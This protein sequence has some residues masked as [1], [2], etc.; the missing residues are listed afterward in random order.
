MS[1]IPRIPFLRRNPRVCRLSA[2]LCY[3]FTHCN[4]SRIALC[5]AQMSQKFTSILIVLLASSF[6]A[7]AQQAPPVQRKDS[8]VVS[9]GISKEQLALEDQLNA[10]ISE[11][12]QAL[13]GG[14][15]ANAIKQYESA[16]DLVQKQP[17]LAEQKDRVLKKLGTGYF[18]ATRFNEAIHTYSDLVDANKKDCESESTAVS[19]CAEA[20]SDLGV[21]KMYDGD[22]IGALASLQDAAAKYAKA[23]KASEFHEFTML[24]IMNEAR[25]K[26]SI[27][28]VLFRLG[29]T[30][31]A[32]ATTEA[33][34]PKL[35]SVQA[36]EEILVGIRNEAGQSLQEAQKL[37]ERLKSTQ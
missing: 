26:L 28:V 31:E 2:S 10:I 1:H 13:K 18:R 27:S 37:L 30:A 11:G 29:R 3:S 24:E 16:I 34:I 36:D 20:E 17:L 6:R 14:D 7:H 32:I 9:A 8:I 15:A 22:F 33:A 23:Q 19:N 12:D 21:A 4:Q 5:G 35:T 25:T